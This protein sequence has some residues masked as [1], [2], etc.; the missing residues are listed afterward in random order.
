MGLGSGGALE[1]RTQTFSNAAS[2]NHV[3]AVKQRSHSRTKIAGE[4]CASIFDG[5]VR[6]FV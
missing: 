4:C 1:E 5:T 2:G 6:K 3:R